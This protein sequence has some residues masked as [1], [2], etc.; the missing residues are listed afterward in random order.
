MI[1][2]IH[3]IAA[4]LSLLLPFPFSSLPLSSP[5][6]VSSTALLSNRDEK[7]NA[8]WVPTLFTKVGYGGKNMVDNEEDDV[9]ED[10][11]SKEEP[12]EWWSDS[13]PKED[14]ETQEEDLGDSKII[15]EEGSNNEE[16]KEEGSDNEEDEEPEEDGEDEDNDNEGN[17]E[18]EEKGA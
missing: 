2:S 18:L 10:S 9:K 5:H 15:E 7:A 11:Y 6:S 17:E 16:P 1:R 4:S 8:N 3:A 14:S 12:E 13:K